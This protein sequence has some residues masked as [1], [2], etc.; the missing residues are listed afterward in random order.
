MT[1]DMTTGVAKVEPV[2]GGR[3]NIIMMPGKGAA[4]PQ[5]NPLQPR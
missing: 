2:R 5:A 4:A 3:V 1:M